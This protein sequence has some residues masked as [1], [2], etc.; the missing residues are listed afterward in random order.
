MEKD[1]SSRSTPALSWGLQSSVS[2]HLEDDIRLGV[3]CPTKTHSPSS[4]LSQCPA[5]PSSFLLLMLDSPP[6]TQS[7]GKYMFNA[8]FQ[9]EAACDAFDIVV[10]WQINT[11]GLRVRLGEQDWEAVV[12]RVA[13]RCGGLLWAEWGMSRL[14]PSPS[15]LQARGLQSDGISK[16]QSLILTLW[17]QRAS[18][19]GSDGTLHFTPVATVQCELPQ[20]KRKIELF[21]QS[22]FCYSTLVIGGSVEALQ[23]RVSAWVCQ[24]W[25]QPSV[26]GCLQLNFRLLKC[27]QDAVLQCCRSFTVLCGP[28]DLH[29]CFELGGNI[30][31]AENSSHNWNAAPACK[32]LHVLSVQ[33]GGLFVWGWEEGRTEGLQ[34]VC[35]SFL[36]GRAG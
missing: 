2:G 15:D 23:P 30:R 26:N 16:L 33:A 36:I 31:F 34:I 21:S 25:V 24:Y 20:G 27:N 4:C 12:S 11:S 6:V 28:F 22:V 18:A 10:H 7:A 5:P 8:S 3:W 13:E 14:P 32:Y 29:S 1:C 17:W 35:C 9:C 19:Q